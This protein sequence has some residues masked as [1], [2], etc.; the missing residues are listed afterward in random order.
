[1]PYTKWLDKRVEWH[2]LPPAGTDNEFVIFTDKLN[3]PQK[4]ALKLLT[5]FFGF[6]PGFSV[7]SSH[8]SYKWR[9]S[10]LMFGGITPHFGEGYTFATHFMKY[11]TTGFWGLGLCYGWERKWVDDLIEVHTGHTPMAQ[12]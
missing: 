6:V 5:L 7:I 10:N 2:G 11:L 8:F 1:M 9:L 4:M 12:P 3:C